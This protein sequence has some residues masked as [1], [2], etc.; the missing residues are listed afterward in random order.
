MALPFEPVGD[1]D[2]QYHFDTYHR[3]TFWTLVIVGHVLL[4]LALLAYFTT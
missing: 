3:F 4:V 1:P 2:L